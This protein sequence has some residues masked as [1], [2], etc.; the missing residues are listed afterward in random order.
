[1]DLETP[2]SSNTNWVYV[3]SGSSLNAGEGFTMK[4]D[5]WV[6]TQILVTGSQNN[7]GSNQRYDFRGKPND[8]TIAIPIARKLVLTGNP[9]PSALIYLFFLL[10]ATNTTGIA[11]FGNKTKQLILTILRIMRLRDLSPLGGSG[12]GVYT[13]ATLYSYDGS[14][15]EVAAVGTGTNYSRRFSPV[16]QGFYD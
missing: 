13:P 1:L 5:L 15:N 8:G 9:Y 3:G 14:G 6:P 4:G 11:Y 2:A 10:D 16:G 7:P 12:N